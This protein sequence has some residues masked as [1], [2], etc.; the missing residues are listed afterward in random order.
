MHDIGKIS[1]VI[2]RR[3]MMFLSTRGLRKHEPECGL[4]PE[5]PTLLNN[6]IQEFFAETQEALPTLKLSES[7][8]K[9]RYPEIKVGGLSEMS[10]G[11]A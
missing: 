7:R 5:T 9:K 2:Y 6:M 4:V 10:V 1:D 8:F 11:K 3:I